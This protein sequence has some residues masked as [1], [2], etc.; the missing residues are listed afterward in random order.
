MKLKHKFL[1]LLLA[2][3]YTSTMLVAFSHHQPSTMAIKNTTILLNAGLQRSLPI[4]E[5]IVLPVVIS[6]TQYAALAR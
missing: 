1:W 3:L 6:S 5:Q 4:R 2:L